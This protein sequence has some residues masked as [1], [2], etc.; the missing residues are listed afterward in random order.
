MRKKS[1]FQE[2]LCNKKIG[3]KLIHFSECMNWKI[4]RMENACKSFRRNITIFHLHVI[5]N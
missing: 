2:V 1:G 5:F 4:T 3:K